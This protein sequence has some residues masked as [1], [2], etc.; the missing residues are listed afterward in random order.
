MFG[1]R[2]KQWLAP[3]RATELFAGCSDGQLAEI[4]NLLTQITIPAG[5]QAVDEG[6]RGREFFI[7]RDGWARLSKHGQDIGQMGAGAFFGEIALLDRGLRTATVRAAT[8]MRVWVM[9]RPEFRELLWRLPSVEEHVVLAAEQRRDS[10][11]L[12][13]AGV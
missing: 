9:N 8:D 3:L 5:V 7:I 1:S 2:E 4:D 11:A 6:A 13:G 12:V 10:D